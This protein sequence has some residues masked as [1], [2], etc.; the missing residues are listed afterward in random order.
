MSTAPVAGGR[1]GHPCPSLL[2]RATLQ[3]AHQ[4]KARPPFFPLFCGFIVSSPIA[5]QPVLHKLV[6]WWGPRLHLSQPEE[7]A[8]GVE[9][10]LAVLVVSDIEKVADWSLCTMI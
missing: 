7:A 5:G 1:G 4:R 10:E 8:V 3:S 2:P 9:Q 6:N